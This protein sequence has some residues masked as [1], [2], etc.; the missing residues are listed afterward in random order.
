MMTIEHTHVEHIRYVDN[1][2][3][4]E[5]DSVKLIYVCHVLERFKRADTARFLAERSR[6]L[7]KG[8]VLRDAVPDF[9]VIC[10]LL[11]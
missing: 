10:A 7:T 5:F 1:F 11:Y 6:V 3:I 9:E 4:V 2:E 8:L